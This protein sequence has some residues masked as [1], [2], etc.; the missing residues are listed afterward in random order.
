MTDIATHRLRG[1]EDAVLE[2][3]GIA[4]R[5]VGLYHANRQANTVQCNCTA[6]Q[7]SHMSIL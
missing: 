4:I 5:L 6:T 3:G 1:A 7:S 2:A